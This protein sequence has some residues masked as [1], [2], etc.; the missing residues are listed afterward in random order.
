MEDSRKNLF[1]KIIEEF[2]L[3]NQ[4][5]SQD[6]LKNI[7]V[8]FAIF[9]HE[10]FGFVIPEKKILKKLPRRNLTKKF[11]LMREAEK[12]WKYLQEQA[13]DGHVDYIFA[14]RDVIQKE[15]SPW[16][17]V[18]EQLDELERIIENYMP[19]QIVSWDFLSFNKNQFILSFVDMWI[20][21]EY[22]STYRRIYIKK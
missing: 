16:L 4:L 10:P 19:N 9:S 6:T 17:I 15:L 12:K 8:L 2:F 22:G 18:V 3:Q 14:Q 13:I 11:Y 5:E 7:D 1:D 21:I 20:Q